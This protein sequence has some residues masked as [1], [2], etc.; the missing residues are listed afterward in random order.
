[1]GSKIVVGALVVAL[2]VL[3]AAEGQVMPT[4]CCRIDCCDGRPECCAAGPWMSVADAAADTPPADVDDVAV[5]SDAK[6]RPA[7]AARKVGAVN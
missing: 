1:M 7:G 5:S 4:P 2:L 3:G 6:A